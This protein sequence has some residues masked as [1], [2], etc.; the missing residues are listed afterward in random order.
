MKK[1]LIMFAHPAKRRSKINAALRTA[2]EGLEGVTVNDLYANYPDFF[3]DVKREQKLCEEHDVIIFQFPLYWYSSPSILKEWQDLV[4]EYGWA[5]GSQGKALQ[6]KMFFLAFTAGADL[7][8]YQ[9]HG[10]NLSSIAEL[11]SPFRSMANLCLLNYFPPFV[12]T[13]VHRGLPEPE[14][15]EYAKE[16]RHLIISIRNEQLDLD[17]AKGAEF[18]NLDYSLIMR[19]E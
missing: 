14:V 15:I 4:L 11:T 7:S 2:V 3:I 8:T 17:T 5:Y 19:E 6:G 18:L 10:Y 9:C 12:V 1:I 13:G 16:Y